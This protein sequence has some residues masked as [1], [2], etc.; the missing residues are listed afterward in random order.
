MQTRGVW[1]V[2]AVPID[3]C[4][5]TMGFFLLVSS[6]CRLLLSQCISVLTAIANCLQLSAAIKV[7]V[8][9]LLAAHR[10]HW[11]VRGV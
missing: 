5:V 2:T 4:V 8:H 10:V 9:C 7:S 11:K 1:V 6:R 3:K